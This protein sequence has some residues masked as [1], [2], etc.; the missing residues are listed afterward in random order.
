MINHS[1]VCKVV[2]GFLMLLLSHNCF[3]QKQLSNDTPSVF[4]PGIVSDEFGNR[5]MA[6]SPLGDEMFYTL[7]S[8]GGR[9]FS[10]I[11]YC[12]KRNGKWS[13]PQVASFSGQYNDLEPA[14]SPD[15]SKLFFSSVRPIAGT[16]AK[17]HDLWFVTKQ[18]GIWTNPVNIGAPV[19][20][21]KDEFYPSITKSGTIYFT[22]VMEGKD[23][24]IVMCRFVNY[25]YDTAVSLPDA[26]NSTGAEFNAF[27]DADEQ[28]IIY[29]AYRRKDNFGTGDLYISKKDSNGIWKEAINLGNKINGQGLTYCPFVTPD[30]KQFFFVSSRGGFRSPFKTQQSIEELK[31]QMYSSLNGSDNIYWMKAETILK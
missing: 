14:F 23:E 6:I 12:K 25:A 18:N 10:V 15:G 1:F 24:D 31:K 30:K 2:T 11:M 29:T 8:G 9:I 22:R 13:H 5:D 21:N 17:D 19:N 4:M 27:I 26:I 20:S 3:S 7:Q 28:F 16:E